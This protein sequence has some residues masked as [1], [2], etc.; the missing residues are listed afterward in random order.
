M[1]TRLAAPELPLQ[2]VC[3]LLTSEA[4]STPFLLASRPALILL[5]PLGQFTPAASLLTAVSVVSVSLVLPPPQ[6][7]ASN[8][9]AIDTAARSA[10]VERQAP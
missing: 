1:R 9:A 5:P 10:C 4:S 6:P 2:T 7:A 3:E 8:E